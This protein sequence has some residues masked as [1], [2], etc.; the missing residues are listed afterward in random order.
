MIDYGDVV[1]VDLCAP[2]GTALAA[3]GER[4]AASSVLTRVPSGAT[5]A[6]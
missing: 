2:G 5:G 6:G 4:A 1:R 3:V